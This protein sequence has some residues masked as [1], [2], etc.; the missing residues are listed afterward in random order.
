MQQTAQP[1]VRQVRNVLEPVPSVKLATAAW[2]PEDPVAV[3]ILSHGHAEHSGRYTYLVNTMVGHGL[4]V[5]TLDHRGHGRSS[6][7]RALVL[8]FDDFVDD[9]DRVVDRAREAFPGL[10]VVLF[11]HS[12]GG[13]I[14]VR[15]ALAHPNKVSLLVTS[16]PALIVD[17]TTPPLAV[18]AIGKLARLMPTAPVPRDDADRLNTDPEIKRQFGRDHRT[19]HGPTRIRTAWEM[20]VAGEDARARL[21]Q[22]T[23]PLLAMHGELDTLTMPRGTEL[24][25]A[26]ASSTDKTIRLWPGMKHEIFNEPDRAEVMRVLLDW[27]DTRLDKGAQR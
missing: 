14:A 24:L 8:R 9:L 15:Y 11:G 25:H 12:M 2:I 20:M 19:Y 4:A 26:N 7:T 18:A 6:G 21:P 5:Y 27:L 13:L 22:L 16:G 1:Q 17:D 23:M 10:P 3:F